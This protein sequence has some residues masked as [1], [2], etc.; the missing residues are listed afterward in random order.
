MH[1]LK[2]IRGGRLPNLVSKRL[3]LKG[4]CKVTFH[5]SE[6]L[7]K[8]EGMNP[9]IPKW[10]PILRVG[11]SMDFQIFRGQFQGSK[12]IGNFLEHR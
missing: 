10:A 1:R 2:S 7:G 6:S 11:V 8:C 9:H 3:H 12:F 5:V 4:K